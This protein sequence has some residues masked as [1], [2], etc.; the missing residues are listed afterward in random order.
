MRVATNSGTLTIPTPCNVGFQSRSAAL[1]ARTYPSSPGLGSLAISGRGATPATAA[2]LC[3]ALLHHTTLSHL[4]LPALSCQRMGA[5]SAAEAVYSV[6]PQLS[7]LTGLTVAVE[8]DRE[9]DASATSA[10][11]RALAAALSALPALASAHLIST[12]NNPKPR[13]PPHNYRSLGSANDAGKALKRRRIAPCIGRAEQLSLNPAIAALSIAP[14]LTALC[15]SC[16][17]ATDQ[18][19]CSGV[20]GP[21]TSL[22]RLLVHAAMPARGSADRSSQ[23]EDLPDHRTCNIGPMPALTTLIWSTDSSSGSALPLSDLLASAAHQ[24]RLSD[25]QLLTGNAQPDDSWH[26]APR[27][28][29]T[30]HAAP[31][32]TA[33]RRGGSGRAVSRRAAPL[34]SAAGQSHAAGHH[35]WEAGAV[36]LSLAINPFAF[37]GSDGGPAAVSSLLQL[38][39]LRTLQLELGVR[40]HSRNSSAVL[41]SVLQPL[42][43]LQHLRELRVALSGGHLEVANAHLSVLRMAP[44]SSLSMLTALSLGLEMSCGLGESLSEHLAPLTGLRALC[45]LGMPCSPSQGSDLRASLGPLTQLTEL[46]LSFNPLNRAVVRCFAECVA[47]MPRL[48]HARLRWCDWVW[49]RINSGEAAWAHASADWVEGLRHLPG[50]GKYEFDVACA[51]VPAA[52]CATVRQELLGRGARVSEDC[53]EIEF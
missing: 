28:A 6:L 24:P 30:A 29:A 2:L 40:G 48:Q 12:C 27:H 53:C 44:L 51:D 41:Q 18:H 37:D 11:M 47:L 10:T 8:S 33:S 50:W 43:C 35:D 1:L 17:A 13:R 15:L 3:N 32:H 20:Q 21:F 38:P 46:E 36:P 23:H 7:N 5:H 45:V 39:R 25:I 31:R 19:P 16:A 52:A 49:H 22:Q 26:A 9:Q 14:A 34:N 42:S 4:S